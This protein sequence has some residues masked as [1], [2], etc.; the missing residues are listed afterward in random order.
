[1]TWNDVSI[2]KLQRCS[3][4]SR[5]SLREWISNFISHF[6]ME[7]ITYP[8]WDQN[9][10][11]LVKGDSVNPK[12]YAEDSRY[13]GG[14]VFARDPWWRHLMKHF[15]RYWTFVRGIHWSPVNSPHKGQC[16][17]AFMF[18][19]IC[20]WINR[21]VNNRETGDLRRYRAHYGVIVMLY[22]SFTCSRDS[23]LYLYIC[24]YLSI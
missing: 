6:I 22:D 15:P 18:S 16:R 10:S 24:L 1:M 20:A 7:I 17:G 5:W 8:C 23:Y 3:R 2:P 9:Q 13:C 4:C 14:Q 12:H 21:W 19:L 11:I